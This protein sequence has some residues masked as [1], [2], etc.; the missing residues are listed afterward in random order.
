ME[1]RINNIDKRLTILENL[2]KV[3]IPIFLGI[4]VIYVLNKSK[5]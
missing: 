2:H 3:A 4:L 5:Q 1:E